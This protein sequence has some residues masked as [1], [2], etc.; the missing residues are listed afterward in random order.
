MDVTSVGMAERLRLETEAGMKPN[1][2]ATLSEMMKFVFQVTNRW[3]TVF[4]VT[5]V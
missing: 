4:V 1:V 2:R 3:M 5:I